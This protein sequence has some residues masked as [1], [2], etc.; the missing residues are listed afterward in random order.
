MYIALALKNE[1]EITTTATR[2]LSDA[3]LRNTPSRR[4]VLSLLLVTDE[5]CTSSTF[6]ST[7]Q[8]DRITIYRTLRTLEEVGLVHRIQDTTGVDKYALCGD[9]CSTAGHHHTHAH[10]YCSS[11]DTTSCL[12]EVEVD[13]RVLPKGYQISESHLTYKGTCPSCN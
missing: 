7:L 12:T 5:T 4:G 3:G 2:L 8:A 13:T 1:T 10:F 9:S 6:E 11:C